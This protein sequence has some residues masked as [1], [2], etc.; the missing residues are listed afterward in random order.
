MV[1]HIREARRAMH[2]FASS[3]DACNVYFAFYVLR[4]VLAM[5]RQIQNRQGTPTLRPLL[6]T[7]TRECTQRM[8]TRRI[9]QQ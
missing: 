8:H 4:N 2:M 3:R 1:G 5:S 6:D 9:H 7:R